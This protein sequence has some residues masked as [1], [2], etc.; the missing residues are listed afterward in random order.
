MKKNN[1]GRLLIQKEFHWK[2]EKFKSVLLDGESPLLKI[3]KDDK[4]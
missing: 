4:M 2:F 1:S 3:F